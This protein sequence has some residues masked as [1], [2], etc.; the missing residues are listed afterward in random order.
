MSFAVSSA[1]VVAGTAVFSATQQNKAAGRMGKNARE[2]AFLSAINAGKEAASMQFEAGEI[3]KAGQRD[4]ELIL[5]KAREFRG[6]Q[7]VAA[8]AAGFVVDS[9][10]MADLQQHTDNLA[11]SDALAMLLDSGSQYVSLTLS[12]ENMITTGA[13]AGQLQARDGAARAD[14]MR[15]QATS[16]LLGGVASFIGSDGGQR[17]LKAVDSRLNAW[18]L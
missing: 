9:G 17:A 3:K 15:A 8:A 16:T 10:T 18:G 1:V 2:S 5:S 14:A 11:R 4:A 7:Q 6:S 13:S 12:A